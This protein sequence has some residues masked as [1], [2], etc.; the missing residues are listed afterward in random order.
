[1]CVQ[2]HRSASCLIGV[3]LSERSEPV[4]GRVV[5]EDPDVERSME[6]DDEEASIIAARLMPHG[7][8]GGEVR[9]RSGTDHPAVG[10]EAAFEYDDRVRGGVRVW[11]ASQARWVADQVARSVGRKRPPQPQPVGASRATRAGR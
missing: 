11:Q 2:S 7:F 6:Q 3:V 9:V 10:V 5:T 1:M 8:A 4:V